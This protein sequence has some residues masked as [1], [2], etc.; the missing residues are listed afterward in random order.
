[1]AKIFDKIGEIAKSAADKTNDM[2]EQGK[3]NS[4]INSE[5]A[6]IADLKVKIGNFYWEKFAAGNAPDTEISEWCE[7][8]KAAKETIAAAQAEI[9]ALKE[10]PA[11]APEAPVPEQATAEGV[12]PSCKTANLPGT[13][14]C[15]ECGARLKVQKPTALHCPS[16][17]VENALG[18]NFCKECG[19]RLA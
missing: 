1:M 11:E 14:F 7:S 17:G 2:I 3:L 5:E 16:C 10:K 8:I 18:T 4:K 13:K 15:K 6:I 9:Q 19:A 12:C